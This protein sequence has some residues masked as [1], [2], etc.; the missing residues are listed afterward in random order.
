M[1]AADVAWTVG[2]T[3]PN[4]WTLESLACTEPAS[5]RDVTVDGSTVRSVREMVRSA[6]AIL[7]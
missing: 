2:E 3:V 6:L 5:G 1:R 4:G 7:R